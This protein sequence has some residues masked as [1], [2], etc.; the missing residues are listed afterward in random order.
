MLVP[1]DFVIPEK[2]D[3]G[4]FLIRKLCAKDVYLDYVAVMSSID[5]IKKVRGGN[6]PTKELT[7]EDDLID[8]GWHQREFEFKNSFAFTV[9]NT[10]QS[11]CLGCIYFYPPRTGMSSAK[12]D[13]QAEVNIS[14]W[15]TQEKYDKGLYPKLFHIVKEWVEKDWPFTRVAYV[16]KE[17]PGGE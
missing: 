6:W 1:K 8:L 3:C 2:L 15:V 7:I 9:M 12:N 17:L 11:R 10:D 13:D 4:E 16:N 5:I 14:M